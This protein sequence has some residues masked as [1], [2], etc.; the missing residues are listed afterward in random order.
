MAQYKNAVYQAVMALGGQTKAANLLKVS[1]VSIQNWI[2]NGRVP[3]ARHAVRLAEA[4]GMDV[5]QLAGEL[6]R[7]GNVGRELK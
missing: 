6:W 2:R 5:R 1:G 4:T 7:K 3:L